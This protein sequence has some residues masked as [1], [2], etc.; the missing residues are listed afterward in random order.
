LWRK[1]YKALPHPRAHLIF[2]SLIWSKGH[3]RHYL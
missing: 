2:L 1:C 3:C